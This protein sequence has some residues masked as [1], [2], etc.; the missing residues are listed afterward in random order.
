[1]NLK[2]IAVVALILGTVIALPFINRA[3]F[4]TACKEVT[5]AGITERVI[6]P[7]ILASGFLAHEEEVM[8]SSEV[9]GRVA[10]LYVE[11]G[12]AVTAGQLVLQVEDINFIAGLEQ[13]EA[14]VRIN[15]IDIERQEIRI[16]NL[17][18][19]YERSRTLT[20]AA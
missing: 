17:E 1:M 9:I 6:S 5:V 7:S 11:E 8:L 3:V 12:D 16:G 14:A 18:N 13:S 19:Q 10:E 4:G 2:K 15:T 20:S